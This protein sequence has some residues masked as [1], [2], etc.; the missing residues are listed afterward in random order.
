MEDGIPLSFLVLPSAYPQ[1]GPHLGQPGRPRPQFVHTFRER[2]RARATWARE[3]QGRRVPCVSAA[4]TWA[5]HRASLKQ[6]A[7]HP[8]NPSSV[9]EINWCF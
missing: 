6:L 9:S 2:H 5:S 7:S 8:G 4:V 3:P 1:P